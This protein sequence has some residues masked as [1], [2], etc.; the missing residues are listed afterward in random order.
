MPVDSGPIA[1]RLRKPGDL[2]HPVADRDQKHL[3]VSAAPQANTR[4]LAKWHVYHAA[5]SQ[6]VLVRLS[7]SYGKGSLRNSSRYYHCLM[8]SRVFCSSQFEWHVRFGSKAAYDV[9]RLCRFLRSSRLSRVDRGDL[10]FERGRQSIRRPSHDTRRP[11]SWNCPPAK[12][13]LC[14]VRIRGLNNF[15]NLIRTPRTFIGVLVVTG[16]VG[17]DAHEQHAAA[18]RRTS[19]THKNSRRL[20]GDRRHTQPNKQN[21]ST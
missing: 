16:L 1:P 4:D 20:I 11:F 10:D 17:K 18:A 15:R 5:Y 8:I 21:R 13:R 6:L 19:R 9:C 14:S 2:R 7:F 3:T 12:R